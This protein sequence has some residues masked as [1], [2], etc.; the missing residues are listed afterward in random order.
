MADDVFEQLAEEVDAA[1]RLRGWEWH[2]EVTTGTD[3]FWCCDLTIVLTPYR[4]DG[5]D[6]SLVTRAGAGKGPGEA[7]RLAWAD[8]QIWLAAAPI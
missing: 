6:R 3:C 4:D 7:F 5:P 8:M 1:C 2:A